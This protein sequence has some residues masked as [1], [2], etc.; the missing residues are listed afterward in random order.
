MGNICGPELAWSCT[1]RVM[2]MILDVKVN[3]IGE[4]VRVGASF[5]ARAEELLKSLDK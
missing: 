5:A 4:D 2:D 3:S 1:I